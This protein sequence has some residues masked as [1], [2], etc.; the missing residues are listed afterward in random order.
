MTR[1]TVYGV[2]TG[3]Y[4]DY[5]VRVLFTTKK[6]AEQHAQAMALADQ[7]DSDASV[8]SFDLYDEQPKRV[9]IHRRWARIDAATGK[10]VDERDG[11]D[12]DWEYGEWWGPAK[13]IMSARTYRAPAYGKDTLV[14]VRGANDKRVAKAY[15][16]RI[17]QAR[18]AFT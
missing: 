8:E 9:V 13:P 12:L 18:E 5:R 2:T 4:S 6:A 17:A 7:A 15:T 10:V 1:A 3:S 16:D 14:E 11:K